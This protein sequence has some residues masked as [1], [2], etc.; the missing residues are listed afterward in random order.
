MEI[1]LEKDLISILPDFARRC[2]AVDPDDHHLFVSLGCAT[3]NLVHAGL[4]HGLRSDVR[5]DPATGAGVRVAFQRAKPVASPLFGAIPMRQ[6]TRGAYDG[7]AIAP[8]ELRALEVAG[9]APGVRILVITA[10]TRME[11]VFEYVV[12]G[13][14]RQMNDPASPG[15]VATQF[16]AHMNPK[17]TAKQMAAPEPVVADILRG[18]ERGNNVV[19]P[20]KL[21]V[22]LSALGA[23]LLPRNLI[24]RLAVGVTKKLNQ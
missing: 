22:R 4:A 3:E 15:P 24:L 5:F 23:R 18:F 17:L 19:Y 9:Q 6:C 2:P 12:Q 1:K 21:G 20:G 16:F 10:R 14:T 8:N 13:N 7:K 11:R